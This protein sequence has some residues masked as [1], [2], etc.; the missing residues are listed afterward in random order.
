MNQESVVAG[1]HRQVRSLLRQPGMG[2][3][4]GVLA[5]LAIL[6]GL[7]DGM[8]MG[9][10]LPVISGLEGRRNPSEE[11][12]HAAAAIDHVFTLLALPQTLWAALG[13]ALAVLIGQAVCT[14][15]R[16]RMTGLWE[17]QLVFAMRS[18]AFD[19]LLRSDLAYIQRARTG[20][21]VNT[22]V[23]EAYRAGYAFRAM[24]EMTSAGCVFFAY[25]VVELAISWKLT[26]LT[27]PVLGIVSVLL[28]PRESYQLGLRYTNEN[29]ALMTSATESLGGIREIKALS[30]L[31]KIRAQYDRAARAIAEVDFQ[32]LE[33]GARFA[34]AYQGT[35][36][37]LVA[38]IILIASRWEA[39]AL[40]PLLVF[41]IV[42]Q[43]LAPRVGTFTE[44]RHVWLG[45]AGAMD[46]VQ[47]L[48]AE[49]KH[50]GHRSSE[51]TEEFE[52]LTQGIEFC[53][54]GFRHAGQSFDTVCDVT[55]A[56]PVGGSVA[57]IGRSGSGKSTRVDLLARFYEPDSGEIRADGKNIREFRMESWRRGLGLVS[58]ETFLFNDTVEN[59][60]RCG[61]VGASEEQVRQ[62]ATLAH[63]HEFI[64]TL[65]DAYQT[66]VGD[67]GG[68]LSGG[69]RQRL[70]LA[71]ALLRNPQI[72][73]LDEAT[74]QL[75][76]ESERAIQQALRDIRAQCTVLMA[77]HRLSAVKDVDHIL[78]LEA[79][80]IVE[81]GAPAALLASGG[82]YAEF[83][84][85][86][87][88]APSSVVA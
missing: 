41:L 43:R 76:V 55:F 24:I 12:N 80:R 27:F 54:V 51:G 21:L 16:Q 73:L 4:A 62:A 56:L 63:A 66:F 69:Q 50:A 33:R 88:A 85:A 79:G 35:V 5:A 83:M 30:I 86:Q 61:M 10:L 60:I 17:N 1:G 20:E 39:F 38:G 67:R 36:V 48:L 6:G 68:R 46:K 59:N 28:K 70:A 77:A 37:V 31:P 2:R 34:L 74:S 57:I 84:K 25:A 64:V 26:L 22:L 9:L 32:L 49:A 58:Q 8:G 13:V 47:S 18:E 23:T 45:S 40:G 7:L 44:Q 3:R 75:D 29:D 52:R 65:P 14:Y 11:T 87:D 15:W 19:Y 82:R 78:V 71:R 53:H 81:S 42:L 72:L